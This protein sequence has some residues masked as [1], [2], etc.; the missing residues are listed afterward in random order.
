M[1][2]VFTLAVVAIG[3]VGACSK[4]ATEP[5]PAASEGNE[6]PPVPATGT[7]PMTK[8][9]D[10]QIAGILASVDDG[11]VEQ[12]RLA[13][14]KATNPEVRTFANH[15]I[16]EHTKSKQ[17]AAQLGLTPAE[18]PKA[19]ELQQA[20]A[21]MLS[22]LN[23]ADANNFDITYVDGQIE[24]HSEVLTLI[25]DQLLPAVN[26]PALREHLNKARSMVDQHLT[27]ARQLKK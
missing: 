12:A 7:T 19:K 14:T 6:A 23:A 13:V 4:G 9:S 8:L 22:Q 25:K 1:L 20:G 26:Q 24:Q 16:E 2:N 10:G 27:H 3:G 15:M 18:S 21:K 11:E 5:Q 17:D